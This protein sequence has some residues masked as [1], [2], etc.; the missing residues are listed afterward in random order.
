MGQSIVSPCILR[1]N[2]E[3][4]KN[5]FV[6]ELVSKTQV[7]YW[8]TLEQLFWCTRPAV[9]AE[10]KAV[11]DGLTSLTLDGKTRLFLRDISRDPE[12]QT[13]VLKTWTNAPGEKQIKITF[14]SRFIILDEAVLSIYQSG[15]Y[16]REAP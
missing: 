14:P 1:F 15:K 13:R 7:P 12:K 8:F 16:Y 4:P 10:E 6:E 2:F 5:V 3:I 9:F 11:L